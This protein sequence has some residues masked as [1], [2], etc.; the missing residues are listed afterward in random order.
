MV[1]FMNE[2]TVTRWVEGP[3]ALDGAG[4]AFT[5]VG[6]SLCRGRGRIAS[7]PIDIDLVLWQGGAE[8]SVHPTRPPLFAWGARRE[9]RYFDAAFELANRVAAEISCR[10]SLVPDAN[11]GVPRSRQQEGLRLHA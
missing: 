6:A 11:E 7:T 9:E 3:I 8:L 4:V 2:L 5:R 10:P 1:S